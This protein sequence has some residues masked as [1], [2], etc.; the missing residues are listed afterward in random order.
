[1]SQDSSIGIATGY[2]LDDWGVRVR[3]PVGSRIFSSPRPD[4]L[5]GPPSFLHN[6]YRGLFPRRWSGQGVKLATHL[7]LVP[8]SKKR[9]SLHPLP[10]TSLFWE[11]RVVC[12]KH[13][14][15]RGVITHQAKVALPE[16]AVWKKALQWS[17]V[18]LSRRRC[19]NACLPLYCCQHCK[20]YPYTAANIVN[21][22]VWMFVSVCILSEQI[23]AGL[24]FW[25]NKFIRAGFDFAFLKWASFFFSLGD[26]NFQWK[27]LSLLVLCSYWN[28]KIPSKVTVSKL[29]FLPTILLKILSNSIF[30]SRFEK[31]CSN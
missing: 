15:Y 19:I 30:S 6:G 10:H 4:R 27:I 31:H 23:N 14:I 29:R 8:R 11:Y 20:S 17:N 1:M 26:W 25:Y 24:F 18:Y 12:I 21:P 22:E 5:W 3:V 9:G 7:Q 28:T 2:G 13:E 16:S